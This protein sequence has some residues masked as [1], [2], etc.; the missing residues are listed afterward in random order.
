MLEAC[1]MCFPLDSQRLVFLRCSIG[2]ILVI[3]V[4][5]HIYQVQHSSQSMQNAAVLYMCCFVHCCIY[6]IMHQWNTYF[7][8]FED[9]RVLFISSQPYFTLTIPGDNSSAE[10][11][12]KAELKKNAT[13]FT[14]Q[15]L[16]IHVSWWNFTSYLPSGVWN[17]TSF[18]WNK[19]GFNTTNSA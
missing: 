16:N 12:L 10:L 15:A 19:H 14:H 18:H 6:R 17:P 4:H 8:I 7:S 5:G 11:K 9:R 2:C 1:I 13:L 3:L